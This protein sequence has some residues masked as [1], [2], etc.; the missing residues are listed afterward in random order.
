[1]QVTMAN[2]DSLKANRLSLQSSCVYKLSLYK[3]DCPAYAKHF[4][5]LVNLLVVI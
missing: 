3:A 2:G 5:K 1:M 4:S